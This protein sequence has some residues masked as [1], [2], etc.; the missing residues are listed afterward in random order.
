MP[1]RR[2]PRRSDP[3]TLPADLLPPDLVERHGLVERLY[4]A[5]LRHLTRPRPWAPMTDLEWESVAPTLWVHGCG[6]AAPG[7]P[8]P[9]RPLPDPRARLDAIFRAV[10]LNGHP[11]ALPCNAH[12]IPKAADGGRAPWSALPEAFGRPD[13]IRRTFR[14]WAAAGPWARLLAESA[15][16]TAPGRRSHFLCCVVR[17]AVRVIGRDTA[18]ALVRRL[19]RCSALPAPSPWLPDPGLSE[20]H[21]PVI[22]A[23]LRRTN[24]GSTWRPSTAPF[25]P[26]RRSQ[27]RKPALRPPPV[28]RGWFPKASGPLAGGFGRAAP[29]RSSVHPP[30]PASLLPRAPL[31][32]AQAMGAA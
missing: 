7:Q 23:A 30:E 6:M 12:G 26:R 19:T 21:T 31:R 22:D 32:N 18:I 17:R 24:G 14:R 5:P 29:S 8:R 10:T 3:K 1:R 4:L 28:S 27:P 2:R 20:I 13:T 25:A 11:C 15:C 16:P 9:G